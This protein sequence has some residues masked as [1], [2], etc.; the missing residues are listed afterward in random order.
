MGTSPC[1]G[2]EGG[3][4]ELQSFGD[5][6]GRA[7][8]GGVTLSTEL[9][10]NFWPRQCGEVTQQIGRNPSSQGDASVPAVAKKFVAG[11]VQGLAYRI[12]NIGRSNR[13]GA[14]AAPSV[15][16]TNC[17]PMVLA[18]AFEPG[19]RIEAGECLRVREPSRGYVPPPSRRQRAQDATLGG[20]PSG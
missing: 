14:A 6:L 13:S 1:S 17:K 5:A 10:G 8:D 18:R 16:V 3:L 7:V 4:A 20:S 15:R 9:V 11:N 19:H 2:S 12:D